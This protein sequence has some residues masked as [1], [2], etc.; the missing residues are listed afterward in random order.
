MEREIHTLLVTP[1]CA[2]A[3]NDVQLQLSSEVRIFISIPL[4]IDSQ[5]WVSGNENVNDMLFLYRI[6]TVSSI[7]TSII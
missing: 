6:S 3:V 1:D 5:I 7:C 4:H 2:V